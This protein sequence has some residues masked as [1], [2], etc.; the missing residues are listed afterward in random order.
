MTAVCDSRLA[1][2]V[3]AIVVLMRHRL[4]G[5]DSLMDRLN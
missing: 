2:G 5:S 3:E 4:G 1:R